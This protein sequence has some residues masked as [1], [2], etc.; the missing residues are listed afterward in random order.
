MVFTDLSH[1]NDGRKLDPALWVFDIDA[2]LTCGN[3]QAAKRV[4]VAVAKYSSVRQ[5]SCQAAHSPTNAKNNGDARLILMASKEE[6]ITR[7]C[8]ACGENLSYATFLFCAGVAVKR[9]HCLFC[10]F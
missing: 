8:A 5:P 3:Q 6:A 7:Y 4:D 1:T 2:P 10:V 9:E